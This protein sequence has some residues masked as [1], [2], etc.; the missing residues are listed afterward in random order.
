MHQHGHHPD[1][2][3][4]PHRY[5]RLATLS[6]V[7]AFIELVVG[8]FSGSLALL[9]DGLHTFLDIGDS[10]FIAYTA[11]RV[12]GLSPER[13][14]TLR[15]RAFAVSLLLISISALFMLIEALDR[16]SG[17]QL[18]SLSWPTLV[19]AVISLNMNGWQLMIHFDAPEEHWNLSH[20]GQTL[21]ILTDIGGSI[22]AIIGTGLSVLADIPAADA[23]AAIVIVALIGWRIVSAIDETWLSG[24]PD[25]AHHH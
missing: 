16:L 5:L 12:Q 2:E 25:N 22:A 9:T 21:H 15:R 23:V 20:R 17:T 10:L 1:H 6:G 14:N 4:E 8:F 24:R 7:T 13:E 3:S 11:K 18:P 19:V